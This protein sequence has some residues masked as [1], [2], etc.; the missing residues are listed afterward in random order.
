MIRV[1]IKTI[2]NLKNIFGAETDFDLPEGSTLADLLSAMANQWGEAFSTKIFQ[3]GT[4]IPLSHIRLM[5]NGRDIAFLNRL[6]TRLHEADQVFIL[7]PV[8]GG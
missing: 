1:K 2:L 7:P 8:S 3:P 6:D 5:V 4:K